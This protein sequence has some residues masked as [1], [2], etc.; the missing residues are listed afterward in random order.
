MTPPPSIVIILPF[1]GPLKSYAP[2]FF[3]SCARNPSVMWLLVTDQL[4]DNLPSNVAVKYLSFEMLK[5]QVDMVLGFSTA[6]TTPY[7]LC[8]FKPA[9]GEIFEEEIDGFEFWG[10]CDMDMIFGDIRRFLTPRILRAFDKVLIHGHFSLYRNNPAANNYFRLKAPG[11]SHTDVFM[12]TKNRAFDEFGGIRILLNHHG[13][14]MFRDDTL[15]ADISPYT[16]RL[17]VVGG[18]NHRHQCFYWEDGRVL[19]EYWGEEGRGFQE[20]LYLHMRSRPMAAPAHEVIG[21]RAW[22]ITPRGFQPKYGEPEGI[23]GLD[24]L[25]PDNVLFAL[26]GFVQQKIDRFQYQ[27]SQRVDPWPRRV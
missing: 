8:D 20:Y 25:N 13:I 6:L 18:E 10:H 24:Q 1:F 2:L 19:R 3:Q 7:K 4:V 23:A 22:Y 5:R 27:L 11:L 9:Y 21:R 26:R 12:S 15:I 14:P 16:Y 17:T